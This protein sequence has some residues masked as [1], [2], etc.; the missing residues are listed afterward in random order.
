[1]HYAEMD[2]PNE[3]RFQHFSSA[4]RCHV[5]NSK[6]KSKDK[7][8]GKMVPRP[9]TNHMGKASDIQFAYQKDGKWFVGGKK[10]PRTCKNVDRMRKVAVERLNAQYGWKDKG[11]FSLETADQGATSWVHIDVRAW[12]A[13]DRDDLYF[14]QTAS[15]LNGAPMVQLLQPGLQTTPQ[16]QAPEQG[17]DVQR[18]ATETEQLLTAVVYCESRGKYNGGEDAD[19]KDAIAACFLNRVYYA[20]LSDGNKK[21]FGSTLLKAI[22][23]GSS[24]HSGS[25][26]KSLMQLDVMKSSEDLAAVLD[27]AASRDHFRLCCESAARM[28]PMPRPICSPKLENKVSAAFNQANDTPPSPRFEKIGHLGAYSF[29]GMKAGR[30]AQ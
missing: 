26:W 29:Y 4:Y 11:K 19:E 17:Q 10:D 22:S 16:P 7:K 5:D 13:K 28:V 14:V 8:T 9:T 25:M 1:M 15:D 27:T 2:H 12:S 30:E 24:A 23:K 21:D 20:T 6:H 18:P 3:I